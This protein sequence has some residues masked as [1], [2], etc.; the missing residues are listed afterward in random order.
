[1]L[2]EGLMGWRGGLGHGEHNKYQKSGF[3]VGRDYEGLFVLPFY[4]TETF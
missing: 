4:P 1:M 3:T 2:G